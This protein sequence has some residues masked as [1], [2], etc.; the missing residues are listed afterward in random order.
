M[1]SVVE[2]MTFPNFLC[3][4]LCKDESYHTYEKAVKRI[5]NLLDEFLEY[6]GK[7]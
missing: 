2:L 3:Y 6:F 5:N 4:K 1:F 7:D